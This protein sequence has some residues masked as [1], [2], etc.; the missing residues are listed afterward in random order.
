[1]LGYLD[2]G[3]G[4]YLLTLIAGGTAGIW[5]AIRTFGSR[6]YRRGKK[7]DETDSE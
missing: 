1:M 5:Y 6:L 4:S 7:E 3:T 2:G